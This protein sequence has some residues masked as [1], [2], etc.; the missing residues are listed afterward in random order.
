MN[1]ERTPL[2]LINGKDSEGKEFL[3]LK[4]FLPFERSWVFWWILF[5][6]LLT[7]FFQKNFV[8]VVISDRDFQ[9]YSQIDS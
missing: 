6:I 3:I 2:L 7:F 9:E 5:V 8:K 4:A 1:N